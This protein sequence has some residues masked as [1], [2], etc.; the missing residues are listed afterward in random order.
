M[1][2]SRQPSKLLEFPKL[3]YKEL[4]EQNK[5]DLQ[6]YVIGKKTDFLTNKPKK[7]RVWNRNYAVWKNEN[8]SYI[9]FDDVCPHK[10]ASLS[11]G[12]I[13]NNN[14]AC[15]YHGYEFNDQGTLVNVPGIC[16]Q[17]SPIYD[18]SKYTVV[19]KNGW[20]YINTMI[21]SKNES[22]I[23]SGEYI[24]EEPEIASNCSVVFLDMEYNC[25]S[26]ILSE[27][28]LDIMHIAFVHSFG[29][30]HHPNPIKEEPPKLVG[31]NHYKSTYY[32]ESGEKSMVRK[33][34]GVTN[35]KIENEFILPHTTIARVIFDDYVSTVMTFA[36]PIGDNKSKLFVKTYRNFWENQ[37]GDAITRNTMYNTMLEDK[38]VVEGIDRRFMDGKFNMKFDKLQNTYK[39]FYKR[40]IHKFDND[41]DT[42]YPE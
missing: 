15:P 16:F 36:L 25:Y 35:L 30:A 18:V 26:R 31:P 42:S 13:V 17:P 24:Y 39:S 8:G 23:T 28:S 22:V 38:L 32:Y 34:F 1:F 29:N 9:G 7:V 33:A 6:W 5:Y 3:N 11:A 14:I 21:P 40:F 12:K 41:N 10:A 2:S 4:T 20:V 37:L 27:N 19:E